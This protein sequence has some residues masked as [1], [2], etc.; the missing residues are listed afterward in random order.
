[1][2]CQYIGNVVN[3]YPTD[4][5]YKNVLEC[6]PDVKPENIKNVMAVSNFDLL[7]TYKDGKRELF[8]TLEGYRRFIKYESDALTEEEHRKEF[9]KILYKM[10]RRKNVS[11]SE[12]AR[13]IGTSQQM[14]SKYI[15]GKALPGYTILKKMSKIFNCSVDDLY[16][17]F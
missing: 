17:K 16:L 11:Q 2:D 10:M 6:N 4:Q 9:P 8:D 1:M 5:L 12:L 15:T 13:K 3:I 14:I 7:I